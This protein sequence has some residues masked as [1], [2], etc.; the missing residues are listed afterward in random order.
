MKNKIKTAALLIIISMGVLISG[1]SSSTGPSG[2]GNDSGPRFVLELSPGSSYR[3]T[4]E[5]LIFSIPV[6]PQAA[7]WLETKDGQYLQ[8]IYVTKKGESGKWVAAPPGK[9][10]V[11]LETNRS[12]DYNEVFTEEV[13]GVGGQPSIIYQA[14]ITVGR[15]RDSAVFSP[16]GTGSP[17]GSDGIIHPDFTG[18]DTALELFSSMKISYRE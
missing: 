6:Y 8:T 17:D 14:E 3:T 4:T 7:V 16:V 9:Y 11:K 1:C 13:S 12:Y 5:W 10:I 18:I 2:A 15:G